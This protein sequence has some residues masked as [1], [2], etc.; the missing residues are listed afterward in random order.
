[1]E[2][3]YNIHEAAEFLGYHANYVRQIARQGKLEYYKAGREFRFTR[4]MLINY[5]KKGTK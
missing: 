5:L 2:K 1:M 4:E 3:L